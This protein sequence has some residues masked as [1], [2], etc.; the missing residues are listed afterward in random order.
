METIEQLLASEPKQLW[1]YF[2]KMCEIP[3]GSKNETA[4]AA[5]IVAEMTALGLVVERDD[6]GNIL[7]RKPASAGLENAP[8]V[9]L[10][11]HVDIVCEKNS[12]TVHDF[13]TDGIKLK[14]VDGFLRAEGTTLGA[15]NGIGAA[16]AMAK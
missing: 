8:T 9:V 10:Q 11:G 16:C 15:D 14:I 5:Y 12:A 13:L 1:H 3:H 6:V 7:V 4:I 2:A